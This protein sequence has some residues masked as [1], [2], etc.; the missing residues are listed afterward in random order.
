MPR[1]DT[2]TIEPSLAER[3]II[4]RVAEARAT[5]PD[6]E[7]GVEAAM[8]GAVALAAAEGVSSTAVLLRAVARSLRETPRANA[9]YRDGRFELYPRVNVSVVI[10]DQLAPTVFDADTKSLRELDGELHAL[11]ERARR[12]ELTAPELSGGTFTVSDLGPLGVDRPGI[13]LTGGQAGALAAGTIREIPV[14]RDG[15]IVPGLSMQLTLAADHR[16]LYGAEAAA[17]LSRV[18]GT[19]EGGTP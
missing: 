3:T 6:L 14:V 1:G 15:A 16:V 5:I 18:K 4:R 10:A 13:V 2:E 8:D 9:A 19:L 11:A 12:S 17:F 7:L